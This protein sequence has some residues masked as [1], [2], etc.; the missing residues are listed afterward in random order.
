MSDD[1]LDQIASGDTL[2]DY[3]V[4][5]A[6]GMAQAQQRLG[7]AAASA[8]SGGVLYQ[9]PRLDFELRLSLS[10]DTSTGGGTGSTKGGRPGKIRVKAPTSRQHVD[11]LSTITGSLVAV[12]IAG[13]QPQVRLELG[14]RPATS[15]EAAALPAGGT[16]IAVVLRLVDA[17]GTPVVGA[18][19]SID[20]DGD[21]SRQ[22]NAQDGLAAG[23][24]ADS[25]VREA[26]VRTDANGN[27]LT[28][29][30]V[31]ALEPASAHLAVTA[32]AAGLT[33]TLIHRV[34]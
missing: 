25:W 29:L 2:D 17:G 12:P 8:S 19:I 15:A 5:L 33:R 30:R 14:L 32:S 27:A 23:P 1:T 28:L 10:M 7:A 22:L 16:A 31:G 4:A 9:I 21:L 11:L 24:T 18:E 13:G 6:D 3:L 26:S 20:L 34:R